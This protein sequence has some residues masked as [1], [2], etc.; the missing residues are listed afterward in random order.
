MYP[1]FGKPG[2]TSCTCLSCHHL[3]ASCIGWNH[4]PFAA[5]TY[6]ALLVLISR[7]PLC[8][9]FPWHSSPNP[10]GGH[11][12]W[13]CG[14]PPGHI[15]FLIAYLQVRGPQRACCLKPLW[16]SLQLSWPPLTFHFIG[17]EQLDQENAR[18]IC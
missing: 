6:L 3:S 13:L 2:S 9:L 7:L 15:L 11:L 5:P 1:D 8:T 16:K 10:S 4:F 14:V 17:E 18:R 12:A